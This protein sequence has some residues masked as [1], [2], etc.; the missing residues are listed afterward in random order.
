MLNVGSDY[1]LVPS[2]FEPGGLVQSE[3]LVMDT[4]VICSSTG[5]LKDT[6]IDIRYE[7]ESGPK[8]KIRPNGLLFLPGNIEGL[9]QAIL[10]AHKIF[11]DHLAV[12]ENRSKSP[13]KPLNPSAYEMLVSNCFESVVDVE[14]MAIKYLEEFHRIKNSIFI[15]NYNIQIDYI[16]RQ[17]KHN[18]NESNRKI[19]LKKQVSFEGDLHRK[20]LLKIDAFDILEQI[21]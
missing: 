6:V 21:Q 12:L 9:A 7:S 5:G 19:F 16:F 13:N 14:T 2:I 8:S 1:G 11:C 17:V 15:P 4:P 3:F 10:E 18:V 20:I